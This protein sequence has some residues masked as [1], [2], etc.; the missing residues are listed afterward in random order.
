MTRITIERPGYPARTHEIVDKWPDGDYQVWN[1]GYNIEHQLGLLPLCRVDA[2]YHC[3][4][5]S[6]KVLNTGDPELCKKI[7]EHA[8]YYTIDATRFKR[9]AAG[10]ITGLFND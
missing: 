7:A 8:G 9:L 1:I 6:H 4:P 10:N 3:I 5:G 2:N